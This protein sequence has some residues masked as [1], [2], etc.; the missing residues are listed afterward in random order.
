MTTFILLF[1]SQATGLLLGCG[2][3]G[4]CGNSAYDFEGS[5]LVKWRE[6]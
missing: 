1:P 6:Q 4:K 5:K 2:N 3:C